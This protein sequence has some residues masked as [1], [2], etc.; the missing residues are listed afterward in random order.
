M[1][2]ILELLSLGFGFLTVVVGYFGGAAAVIIGALC[3][4]HGFYAESLKYAMLGVA[5]IPT[6]LLGIGYAMKKTT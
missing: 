1:K 5:L 4:F 2:Y 6:G 3:T